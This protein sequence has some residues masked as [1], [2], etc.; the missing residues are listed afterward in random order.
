ML[1]DFF[2]HQRNQTIIHV[3]VGSSLHNLGYVLVVEPQN[4][5][6]TFI[7]VLVVESELDGLTLLQLNFSCATLNRTR[8]EFVDCQVEHHCRKHLYTSI[9]ALNQKCSP[10]SLGNSV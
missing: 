5:L 1:T 4:F 8:G 7:H 2:D 6:I 9:C 10:L 3:D